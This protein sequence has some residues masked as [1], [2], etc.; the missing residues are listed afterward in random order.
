MNLQDYEESDGFYN[1]SNVAPG[2]A[3][4]IKK[5]KRKRVARNS[6]IS[7]FWTTL[8]LYISFRVQSRWQHPYRLLHRGKRPRFYRRVVR[9]R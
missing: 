1:N 7:E 5:V 3:G 4:D 2:R 8:F 6:L 9:G